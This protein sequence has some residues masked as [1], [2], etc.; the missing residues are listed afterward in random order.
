MGRVIL[1]E[2][3]FDAKANPTRMV[4]RCCM[5]VVLVQSVVVAQCP[6]ISGT[7]Y[8]LRVSPKNRAP[9]GW[10]KVYTVRYDTQNELNKQ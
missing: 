7:I 9:F 2:Y 5:Q 6:I 8:M 3:P 10:K 1:S 4:A